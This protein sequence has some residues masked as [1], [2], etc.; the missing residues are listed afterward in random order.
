MGRTRKPIGETSIEKDGGLSCRRRRPLSDRLVAR[1]C[2]GAGFGRRAPDHRARM[3]P[4]A[5]A[6]REAPLDAGLARARSGATQLPHAQLRQAA[7]IM[8]DEMSEPMRFSRRLCGPEC[9]RPSDALRGSWRAAKRLAY[10]RESTSRIRRT[11]RNAISSRQSQPCALGWPDSRR[12]DCPMSLPPA[13]KFMT[14]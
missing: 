2:V 4:S 11:D 13:R 8:L 1:D 9:A 7:K 14:Q 5:A 3:A 6:D 12:G 10:P